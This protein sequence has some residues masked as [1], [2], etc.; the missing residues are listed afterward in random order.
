MNREPRFFQDERNPFTETAAR[1]KKEGEEPLVP[2]RQNMLQ[3]GPVELPASP[4][5]EVWNG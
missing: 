1:K 5:T 2:H 4:R 3:S